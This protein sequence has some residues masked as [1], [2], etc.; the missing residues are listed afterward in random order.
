MKILHIHFCSSPNIGRGIRLYIQSHSAEN[1][2][3][4]C[5]IQTLD[6]DGNIRLWRNLFI[7]TGLVIGV[8]MVAVTVL[9]QSIE[10]REAFV[11]DTVILPCSIDRTKALWDVFWRD[12]EEKV[13]VDFFE[14]KEVF[15]DQS[16]EY[17][18][19]VQTFQTEIANG[20]F[21]IKLSNVKLSDSGTY[22]CHVPGPAQSVKLTVK[23]GISVLVCVSLYYCVQCVLECISVC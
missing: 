21:S 12:D 19:R 15:S 17:R 7:I 14:G 2:T 22:T 4:V 5:Q 11:G 13:V 10:T 8:V 23:V 18:D 9:V 20:N 6:K 3:E 16:P 1:Q